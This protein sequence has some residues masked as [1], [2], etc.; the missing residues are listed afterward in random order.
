MR[1]NC[2]YD[3]AGATDALGISDLAD[4]D[5]VMQRWPVILAFLEEHADQSVAAVLVIL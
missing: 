3:A 2:S 1:C 4:G 5:L